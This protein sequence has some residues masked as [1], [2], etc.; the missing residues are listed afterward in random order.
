MSQLPIIGAARRPLIPFH[1]SISDALANLRA[2]EEQETLLGDDEIA[3]PDGCLRDAQTGPRNL[4]AVDP[5]IGLPVYE[6]I[7]R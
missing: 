6:S 2:R 1:R 4:V 5:W 3:D 7:H